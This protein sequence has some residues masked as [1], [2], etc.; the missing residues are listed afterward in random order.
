[1]RWAP[2]VE[3]AFSCGVCWYTVLVRHVLRNA[4][5]PVAALAA[6]EFGI[7]VLAVSSLSFLGYGAAPPTPEWG[8]LISEGRNY[9]ATAWWLTALPGP[10]IVVMVL[11][12]QRIGRALAQEGLR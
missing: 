2:Y 12:T 6:V 5:A 10:V 11:A 7:A 8:L 4:H 9:L 3:A 1:M